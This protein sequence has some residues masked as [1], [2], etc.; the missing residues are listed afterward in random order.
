MFFAE[1]E[2]KWYSIEG[3]EREKESLTWL[4][5]CS[6]LPSTTNLYWCSPSG[7]STM[8]TKSPS[9]LTIWYLK[10]IEFRTSNKNR[11]LV[12]PS[13]ACL[14]CP[15]SWW[16]SPP[17]APP[18]PCAPNTWTHTGSSWADRT[19][20]AAAAV[21][22]ALDCPLRPGTWKRH[23]RPWDSTFQIVII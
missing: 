3:R 16:M 19:L 11:V 12:H 22:P 15:S 7:K 14:T 5:S 6:H 10:W 4:G 2:A 1:H 13:T 18:W 20:A 17:V 23:A 9:L 8:T 21:R